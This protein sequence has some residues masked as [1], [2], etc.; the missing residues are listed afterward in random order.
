MKDAAIALLLGVPAAAW[1]L[2]FG[3]MTAG[4]GIPI[5]QLEFVSVG[6]FLLIYPVAVGIVYAIRR[7]Y[8]S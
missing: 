7:T 2:L 1:F 4:P 3:L 6:M 8:R 5:Q